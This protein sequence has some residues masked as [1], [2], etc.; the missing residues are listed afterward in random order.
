MLMSLEATNHAR[1]GALHDDPFC[2][3]M[4]RLARTYSPM[5][6]PTYGRFPQRTSIP[7]DLYPFTPPCRVKPKIG[8]KQRGEVCSIFIG[9]F[10]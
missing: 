7:P 4:A 9:S 8:A 6:L 1:P 10:F 5:D 3:A 2:S